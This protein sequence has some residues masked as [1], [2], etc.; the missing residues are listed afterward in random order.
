MVLVL[1][2]KLS[3]FAEVHRESKTRGKTGV[4]GWPTMETADE[5]VLEEY[6]AELSETRTL[7]EFQTQLETFKEKFYC[8]DPNPK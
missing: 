8:K 1:A 7:T 6:G 4:W 2:V 5:T 3:S